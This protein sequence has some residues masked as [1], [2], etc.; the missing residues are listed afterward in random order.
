MQV[1]DIALARI[2]SGVLLDIG[3]NIGEYI[4]KLL[5]K[6]GCQVIGF[7]PSLAPYKESINKFPKA[8]IQF[9]ALSN[10]VGS[11]TLKIPVIG[12]NNDYGCGSIVK[13]FPEPTLIGGESLS[14]IEQVVPVNKLDSY[15]LN[16]L[17]F[18]KIDVEGAE[19]EALEGGWETIKRELPD[20]YIELE[21][22]HR[23]D[24]FKTVSGMLKELGYRGYFNYSDKILS[25]DE[26]NQETMQK[27]TFDNVGAHDRIGEYVW[28]FL[29]TTK[30]LT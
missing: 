23:H 22:V 8:N 16:N 30:E 27:C 14:V 9:V 25:T 4:E 24:C 18:I 21:E 28:N 11:A 2:D 13:D 29:F 7:E 12:G 6:E 20:I 1:D 10:Y 3:S 15:E 17:K 26:F 5:N 19:Q